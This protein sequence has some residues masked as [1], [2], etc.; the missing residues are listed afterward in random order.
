MVQLTSENPFL[1]WTKTRKVKE[2]KKMLCVVDERDVVQK[3]K[4]LNCNKKKTD[5]SNKTY[6]HC[7]YNSVIILHIGHYIH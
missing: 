2:K 1:Y 4:T 3:G 6:H 5:E 7:K